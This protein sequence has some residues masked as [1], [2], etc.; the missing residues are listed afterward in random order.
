MPKVTY[1]LVI[2]LAALAGMVWGKDIPGKCNLYG[3]IQFVQTFP[4]VKVQVVTFLI[5]G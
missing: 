2:I 3:R 5:C 4:D 1:I